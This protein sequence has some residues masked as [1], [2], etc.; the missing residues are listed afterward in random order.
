MNGWMDEWMDEWMDGWMYGANSVDGSG[1]ADTAGIAAHHHHHH[2]CADAAEP[3]T[4]QRRVSRSCGCAAAMTVP[5]P[6]TPLTPPHSRPMA[7]VVQRPR[8]VPTEME[9]RRHR[10]H[11][12][13]RRHRDSSSS[14]TRWWLTGSC[15]P[16]RK[17][18]DKEYY[19]VVENRSKGGRLHSLTISIDLLW[20]MSMILL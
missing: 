12:H 19:I 17:R 16:R 1:D 10:L 6:P 15:S 9:S 3:M 11:R 2:H 14:V 18:A 20:S 5:T 8:P 4:G 13:Q 7:A